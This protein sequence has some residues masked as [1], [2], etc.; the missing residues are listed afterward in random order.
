MIFERSRIALFGK[1][2]MGLPFAWTEQS[3]STY[4]TPSNASGGGIL[5]RRSTGGVL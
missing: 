4:S 1:S 3:N 5:P 2:H